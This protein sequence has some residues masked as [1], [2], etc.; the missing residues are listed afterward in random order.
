M[1]CLRRFKICSGGALRS[2]GKGNSGFRVSFEQ[3]GSGIK[4]SEYL[5]IASLLSLVTTLT[6]EG[7]TQSQ[8]LLARSLILE[9]LSAVILCIIIP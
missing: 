4:G 7:G 5:S 8:A 2:F 1:H 6:G 3:L 9:L